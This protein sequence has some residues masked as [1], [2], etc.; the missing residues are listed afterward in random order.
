MVQLAINILEIIG[1]LLI[2][3]VSIDTYGS[4]RRI[5]PRVALGLLVLAGM[6]FL[7][8]LVLLIISNV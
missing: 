8:G 2:G 6:L 1:L 7:T 3:L 5:K 4:K